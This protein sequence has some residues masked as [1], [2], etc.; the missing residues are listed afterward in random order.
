MYNEYEE[1]NIEP[2]SWLNNEYAPIEWKI[3]EIMETIQNE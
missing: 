2:I 1:V 3:K